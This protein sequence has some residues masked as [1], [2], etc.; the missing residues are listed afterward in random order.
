M[1]ID[2]LPVMMAVWTIV[3]ECLVGVNSDLRLLSGT[4]V[5]SRQYCVSLRMDVS[6]GDRLWNVV[7][8]DVG[9]A[10]GRGLIGSIVL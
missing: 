9:M 8:N 3:L 7:L 5:P 4:T 10:T 1:P 6:L 2:V